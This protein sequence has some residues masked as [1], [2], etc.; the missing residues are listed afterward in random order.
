VKE[1]MVW[2]VVSPGCIRGRGGEREHRKN[3]ECD[4]KCDRKCDRN[5]RKPAPPP[6]AR[7]SPLPTYA[8]VWLHVP[9]FS[10]SRH[11]FSID[12]AGAAIACCV[13]RWIFCCSAATESMTPFASLAEWTGAIMA[14]V[15][16]AIFSRSSFSWA[17]SARFSS[18]SFALLSVSTWGMDG[19]GG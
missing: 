14:C 12:P 3:I 17:S 18:S 15:S 13:S 4:R 19:G 10:S 2:G 5:A 16:L 1:E 8:R 9:G 7:M 6:R 11:V